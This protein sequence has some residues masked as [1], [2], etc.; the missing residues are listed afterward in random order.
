MLVCESFPRAALSLASEMLDETE[1]LFGAQLRK[2]TDLWRR[3]Q[4]SPTPGTQARI[5]RSAIRR[6]TAKA[7]RCEARACMI[8]G[9]GRGHA[10]HPLAGPDF[11]WA[12]EIT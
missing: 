2:Q 9:Y 4:R 11:V 8:E 12:Q 3:A 6:P 7:G 5:T 10:F 1:A